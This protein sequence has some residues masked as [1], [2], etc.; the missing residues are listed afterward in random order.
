MR[1]PRAVNRSERFLA[2]ISRRAADEISRGGRL[3]KH[4][5]IIGD[6]IVVLLNRCRGNAVGPGQNLAAVLVSGPHRRLGAAIGAEATDCPNAFTTENEVKV[7]LV[8]VS[9]PRLPSITMSPSW[10]A[11]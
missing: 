6:G 5:E 9:S 1:C 11:S 10:G 2:G 7:V 4:R 8:K 3:R